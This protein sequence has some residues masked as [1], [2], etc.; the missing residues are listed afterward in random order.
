[1]E[2][3]K[4]TKFFKVYGEHDPEYLENF[5]RYTDGDGRRY[6]LGDLANPNKNRPNL[7]YEFLGVTR[8]W[9]W[10]KERMEKAYKEGRIVQS[11][12]D[13]VPSYKRYLDEMLGQPI[14]DNWD[15]IEHL[16]GA[17]AETLG[18]PTQKPL[19]LLERIIQSS[20]NEG[21][22]ILDPFCGCGTA[23]HAAQK[24]NRKWIGIDVTH[25]AISLIEK[26]MKDAFPGISF[27]VHGVPK[28][29]EGAVDLAR[30]DKY[31]FQWW[32]CSLVN[33]QPYQGKKKGSDTGI[34]GLL[35][36]LEDPDEPPQKIVV[37]VK[38]GEHVGSFMIRDLKGVVDRE[39]AIIGLFITL[40]EP[41]RD[42]LKEAS[43]AGFHEVGTMQY[44][45]IQILTIKGLLEG[46]ERPEYFDQH[47]VK[48]SGGFK[49]AKKEASSLKLSK[50]P[51]R[52][53]DG[54]AIAAEDES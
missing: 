36:P 18:Y 9:R 1:M 51:F 45:K 31:Q 34:D 22:I 52:S 2:N 8:V 14:T 17:N 54:E 5:Y 10:T 44:P 21:D 25:L 35:F 41:T 26:R 16:H 15:D 42:M 3:R 30:R 43:S 37:S 20:S 7:T 38:G 4:K 28:D 53:V 49:K 32:A 6:R 13:G 46:R 40:T 27:E 48:G 33:A 19:A 11:K 24:L 23:V 47:I 39:K 50:L 29:F 12:P